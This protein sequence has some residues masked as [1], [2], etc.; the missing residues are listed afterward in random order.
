V[1]RQTFG[2]ALR[3]FL[4]GYLA[5]GQRVIADDAIACEPNI[6]LRRAGL[7]IGPGITQEVTVQF[8]LAA[9]KSFNRVI[10]AELLDAALCAH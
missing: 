6:G 7:L 10:G 4:P 2:E 9:V 1:P 5:D 8:L 3:R